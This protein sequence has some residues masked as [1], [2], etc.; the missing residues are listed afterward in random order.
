MAR[1]AKASKTDFDTSYPLLPL[2][3]IVVYPH[4]V[5]PLYV[6]RQKS[7][8]ALEVAMDQGTDVLLVTQRD[9]GVENV[10]IDDLY[11]VG[12]L[13]TVVQLLKLQDGT[14]KALVEGNSRRRL[15]EMD[16]DDGYF[17]ARA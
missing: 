2:R 3:D 9:G 17:E 11:T 16:D 8:D 13:A 15:I 1:K 10:E 14:V 12:T 5:V 6:G 4:M 7:I